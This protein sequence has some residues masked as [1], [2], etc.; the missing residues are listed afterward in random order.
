MLIRSY[1]NETIM[2]VSVDNI[3]LKDDKL[4]NMY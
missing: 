3:H 4:L 1:N 2:I